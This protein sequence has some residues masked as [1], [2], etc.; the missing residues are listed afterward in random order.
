MGGL[1][2]ALLVLAPFCLFEVTTGACQEACWE[3]CF[4]QTFR[5]ETARYKEVY[6]YILETALEIKALKNIYNVTKVGFIIDAT[7]SK[8]DA[9]NGTIGGVTG[10]LA[11]GII[12]FQ[13]LIAVILMTILGSNNY[14]VQFDEESAWSCRG[15]NC[16]DFCTASL[17]YSFQSAAE[18]SETS[19]C[20][21]NLEAGCSL[22]N[23]MMTTTNCVNSTNNNRLI[24]AIVNSDFYINNP[25][26]RYK[27]EHHHHNICPAPHWGSSSSSSSEEWGHFSPCKSYFDNRVI[28]GTHSSE[29]DEMEKFRSKHGINRYMRESIFTALAL[30]N[31]LPC[32]L[33]NCCIPA[34]AA[35]PA[36]LPTITPGNCY[37]THGPFGEIVYNYTTHPALVGTGMINSIAGVNF[38]AL[39]QGG[40]INIAGLL[41]GI[42]NLFG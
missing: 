25:L 36:G 6:D 10:N 4:E 31:L 40:P 19:F 15:F 14:L 33:P 17:A 9:K 20:P 42:S 7:V 18:I 27:F 23:R 37:K 28:F 38:T 39:F 12:G 1:K 11:Q 41:Q 35:A 3:T 2:F 26:S 34:A 8:Y 21:G 16:L 29:D 13:Y 22:M 32:M 30:G 5:N 24:V